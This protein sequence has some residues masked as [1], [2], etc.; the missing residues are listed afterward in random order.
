L[1]FE[2]I[3]MTHFFDHGKSALWMARGAGATQSNI[4]IYGMYSATGRYFPQKEINTS[5]GIKY[6]AAV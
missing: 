6:P 5:S 3:L 2:V 1:I 4:G